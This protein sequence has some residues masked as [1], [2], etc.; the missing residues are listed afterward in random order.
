MNI[1]EAA[2][3]SQ[4]EIERALLRHAVDAA[5]N[6][7]DPGRA[8]AVVRQEMLEK[9]AVLDARIAALPLK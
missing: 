7:Q 1:R 8:H 5:R 6:N 3:S 4:T 2:L 9:I